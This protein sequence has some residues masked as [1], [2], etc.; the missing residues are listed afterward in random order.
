M[1]SFK[2]LTRDEQRAEMRRIAF[3]RTSRR[4]QPAG[5]TACPARLLVSTFGTLMLPAE[6]H[7]CAQVERHALAR[8]AGASAVHALRDPLGPSRVRDGSSCC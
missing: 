5:S 1:R 7:Q 8:S 4:W 6:L 3:M 2:N